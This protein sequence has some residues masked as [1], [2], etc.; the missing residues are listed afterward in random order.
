[1]AIQLQDAYNSF[2][3]FKKDISDISLTLFVRWCDRI[4]KF[5]YRK[6]L[7]VD[8]E[9]FLNSQQITITSGT[10]TSSLPADFKDITPLGS[11]IFKLS[12]TLIPTG[13]RLT[14]T[15]YGSQQEGYYINKGLIFFTPIPTQ[16]AFYTL[17]YSP[18]ITKL[19]SL[20]NY[21]TTD[22]T[23]TGTILIPDEY[24]YLLDSALDIFYT[25]WDEDPNAEFMANPRF[26]NALDDIFSNIPQTPTVYGLSDFSANY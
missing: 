18:V 5:I 24:D 17:R 8:P 7:G 16:T 23:Q 3:D 9:R 11:G 1:M 2:S 14:K 20:N 26:V 6:L 15:G 19:T 21:F 25:A 10:Q 12:N 22:G 13:E 4:N